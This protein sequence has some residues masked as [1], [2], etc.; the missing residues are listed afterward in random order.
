M[1]EVERTSVVID[2]SAINFPTSVNPK[3]KIFIN[4]YN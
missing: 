3:I 1:E 4:T 2:Y